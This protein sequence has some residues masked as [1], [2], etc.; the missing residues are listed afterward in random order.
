MHRGVLGYPL[1]AGGRRL[2]LIGLR[3]SFRVPRRIYTFGQ[4]LTVMTGS[5]LAS[6]RST[7]PS[8]TVAPRYCINAQYFDAAPCPLSRC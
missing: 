7:S 2:S 8:E 5:F 4:E 1:A 6:L 3:G